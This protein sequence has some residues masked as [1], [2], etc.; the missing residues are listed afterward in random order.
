[1]DNRTTISVEEYCSYYSIEASFVRTLN[2]HGLLELTENNQSYWI[3]Y[4][5][6]PLLE[7]YT[8]FHYELDINMEGIEAISHLLQ[9]ID[10]LQQEIKMLRNCTQPIKD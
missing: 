2:E 3:E 4:E 1:M 6:L 5:H 9:K 8:H 10:I 7:R